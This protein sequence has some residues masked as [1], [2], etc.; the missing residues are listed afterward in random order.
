MQV[1][2][3][4]GGLGTRLSEETQ[5][6][7]K[8]MVE[9]GGK[10]ILW[11]IM[12]IYQGYSFN[13]FTLALG[14]KGEVIK[15][16]F[17]NYKESSNDL[18]L[19]V[20]TGKLKYL[21]D[22][23]EDWNISLID[24]GKDTLTGGRLLRLKDSMSSTFMLTYGDGLCDVNLKEL[25]A[26][27]K[28]HKKIATVTAVRP[29]A[30]FGGMNLDNNIVKEFQEKPQ[31]GEGWINGGYFIFEP[32]VFD[33]LDNDDSIL[34]RDCLEN[35]AKDGQLMAYQHEG[36]WQC[37]DTLREKTVL[38]NMCSSGDTPWLKD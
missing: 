1:V 31:A 16:F 21:T 23:S 35:L 18:V 6:K 33:Y 7:P 34:E 22:I 36:F 25:V 26:F 3:L 17:I 29:T 37:M 10:P 32:E 13:D 11:H 4:C 27:H 38:D 15:D 14:Y 28:A 2:I 24:T 12:K 9:I 5:L 8:P 30:R 20:K 19:N